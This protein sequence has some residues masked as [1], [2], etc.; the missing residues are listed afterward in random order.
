MLGSAS[1]TTSGAA[2][3]P[4]AAAFFLAALSFLTGKAAADATQLDSSCSIAAAPSASGFGAQPHLQGTCVLHTCSSTIGPFPDPHHGS[5][6][7]FLADVF[8]AG[9]SVYFVGVNKGVTASEW[10]G[11]H[12]FH[13][14][15]STPRRDGNA[16]PGGLFTEDS[17]PKASSPDGFASK[18]VSSQGLAS[19]GFPSDDPSSCASKS[20][21]PPEDQ[22]PELFYSDDHPPRHHR[23]LCVF[24]DGGITVTDVVHRKLA[25]DAHYTNLVMML[26]C[27]IPVHYRALVEPP[28]GATSLTVSLHAMTHLEG[29]LGTRPVMGNPWNSL[30]DIPVCGGAWPSHARSLP[31]S[32]RSQSTLLDRGNGQRAHSP[33]GGEAEERPL[34]ANALE[35][36]FSEKNFP[37]RDPSERISSEINSSEG[38]HRE[39]I[40]DGVVTEPLTAQPV[41]HQVPI[42]HLGRPGDE[43]PEKKRYRVSLMTRLKMAY[44]WYRVPGVYE[45][46]SPASGTK[47]VVVSPAAVLTWILWHR[48]I[49]IE[50]FYIYDNDEAPGGQLERVLR[51]YIDSGLV[52]YIW[53]PLGDSVRDYGVCADATSHVTCLAG[54]QV[55]TGQMAALNGA[56]RRFASETQYL[57]HWDV[58]EYLVPVGPKLAS[59]GG[60]LDEY[61]APGVDTLA[62]PMSLFSTCDGD[63]IRAGM[64]PFD[65]AGCQKPGNDR[66]GKCIHRT[67]RVLYASSHRAFATVDNRVPVTRQVARSDVII[68]HFQRRPYRDYDVEGFEG[69]ARSNYTVR[70]NIAVLREGWIQE[71]V[72]AALRELDQGYDGRLGDSQA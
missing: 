62:L 32:G 8:A 11:A 69:V 60:L 18:N 45:L 33:E 12:E 47:D 48:S 30:R 23:F 37:E 58:D 10:R 20:S 6:L 28:R 50:H 67:D 4:L 71:Q 31:A 65:R 55:R 56:L 46:P 29:P 70:H 22:P 63:T 36:Y 35:R 9:H 42:N 61:G 40:R 43:M 3:F 16:P 53:F 54:Y 57:G 44:R 68:A 59:V 27:D 7:P 72:A 2:G 1:S 13:S 21:S 26:R 51:R 25:G 38:S 66:F 52:T 19:K 15:D 34:E 24:P 5:G 64:L 14:Q 17:P 41:G 39:R 49:G